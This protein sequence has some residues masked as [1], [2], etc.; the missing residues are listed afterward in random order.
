DRICEL[1]VRFGAALIALT[2]DEEGMAKTADRKL[3][4]A[5][6]IHRLCT[7]RHGIPAEAIIYDPLTFTIGS[8]DEDS[9]QAGIETLEGIRLIKARVPGARTLLG[10]SNIS[11]GLKPSPRQILN[12]V[13]LNEAITAGLD[14]C[15]V[16]AKKILP[17]HK[18]SDEI[19]EITRDLIFDRRNEG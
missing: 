6:R 12:S 13:F 15:I 7:A 11:F 9:R 1:A 2:I 19:V 8:G 18:I 10:L 4:V 17:L 5:E 16:N 3:A 14:A